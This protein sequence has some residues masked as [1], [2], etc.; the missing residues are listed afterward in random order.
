VLS[1]EVL[2]FKNQV[3]SFARGSW[4]GGNPILFFK[5]S[6]SVG[7]FFPFPLKKIED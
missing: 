2:I 6:F 5:M 7:F 4:S 1:S 3:S